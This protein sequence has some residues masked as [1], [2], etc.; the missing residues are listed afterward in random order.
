MV[1]GNR[2]GQVG[3]GTG[4][5]ADTALAIEKA[6]RAARKHLVAV[7]L[8]E[9]HTIP[10]VLRAKYNASVVELRP[11]TGRGLVAGSSVRDVLELVGLTNISAKLHSRSKNKLNNARAAIKALA[12]I[13]KPAVAKPE[14]ATARR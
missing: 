6:V 12:E 9:N 5:A 2:N 1:I 4:K 14:H 10:H 13:S 8:G 7:P 11:G 3:V